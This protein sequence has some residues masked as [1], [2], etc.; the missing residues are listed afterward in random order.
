MLTLDKNRTWLL[1]CHVLW[2][3]SQGL[4]LQFVERSTEVVA[5]IQDKQMINDACVAYNDDIPNQY[6]A[7][8]D[9]GI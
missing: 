8:S 2:H 3:A 1:H 7:Q 5:T 4:A 9:S 6:Y